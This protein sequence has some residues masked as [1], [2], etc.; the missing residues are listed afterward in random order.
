M[1]YIRNNGA[2]ICPACQGFSLI[3]LMV[4]MAIGL[5]LITG[6]LVVY[7][8]GHRSQAAVDK[9]V[10]MVDNAR[11]A[12]ETISADLRQAGVYGR[13]NFANVAASAALGVPKVTPGTLAGVA[14]AG[15][16]AAGWVIDWTAP[17]RVLNANTYGGACMVNYWQGDILETRYTLQTPV[18]AATL[19]LAANANQ[20]F[21][22]T[23][24]KNA[25]FFQGNN[26]PNPPAVLP[27]PSNGF[28]DHAYVLNAYYIARNSDN[29]A[30][31]IPSLHQVSLRPDGTVVD[32]VLL[33][34][35]ENMRIQIGMG[36]DSNADGISDSFIYLNPAAVTTLIGADTVQIWLVVRSTEGVTGIDTSRNNVSFAGGTIN[37][38]NDGIR[39]NVVST[40]V[41]LRNI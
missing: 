35:V 10:E 22:N 36:T 7:V 23:T 27:A 41:S 21:V 13:V 5:F 14:F 20:I 34:G 30:D 18:L 6:V 31:G 1:K 24:V 25:Q 9:Q 26:S 2:S 11:F 37:F 4:A 40:V 33:S 15:E 3:E 16:C 28:T 19:A 38:P 17:V 29:A 32:Q 8:N 12:L 39:R